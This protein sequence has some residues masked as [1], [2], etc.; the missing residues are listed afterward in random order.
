MVDAPAPPAP[1]SS[2]APP[3]HRRS[4]RKPTH[5][6]YFILIV[7]GVCLLT[8]S[9]LD[10]IVDHY[11][12]KF[13]YG[14]VSIWL[15]V[16]TSLTAV[17]G[18]AHI[19][20]IYQQF[21]VFEEADD[22]AQFPG[23]LNSPWEVRLR[24]VL[25]IA[26]IGALSKADALFEL[27]ASIPKPFQLVGYRP[28]WLFQKLSE[29]AV[30]RLR[31]EHQPENYTI[32]CA[33][34]FAILIAWS[35]C[36]YQTVHKVMKRTVF[37]WIVTDSIGCLFWGFCAMAVSIKPDADGNGGIGIATFTFGL[38]YLL[39]VVIRFSLGSRWGSALAT[40]LLSLDDPKS[41]TRFSL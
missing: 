25:F 21:Y 19:W 32:G 27:I 36:A 35:F 22:D 18:G 8:I 2:A 24:Y 1:D 41:P 12:N 29:F 6:I 40:K 9:I 11:A 30:D 14:K 31:P 37:V 34:V 20:R 16:L 38:L 26:L 15:L 17:A 13:T 39:I 10:H 3:A 33:I 28:T 7:I 23:W 5:I 4:V